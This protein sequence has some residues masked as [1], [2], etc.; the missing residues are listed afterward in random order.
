[1]I[2]FVGADNLIYPARD[3][4]GNDEAVVL[5]SVSESPPPI[6]RGFY[7]RN[8]LMQKPCGRPPSSIN[9]FGKPL[10][11]LPPSSISDDRAAINWSRVSSATQWSWILRQP[12]LYGERFPGIIRRTTFSP[13]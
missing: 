3:V 2:S 10:P 12:G 5:V 6:S 7:Q 13:K 11:E 4:F 8:L 1:M 9:I